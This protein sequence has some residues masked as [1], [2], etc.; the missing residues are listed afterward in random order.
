MQLVVEASKIDNIPKKRELDGPN[1]SSLEMPDGSG[2]VNNDTGTSAHT[3]EV[4]VTTNRSLERH[5][6]FVSN[7][8]TKN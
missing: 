1:K 4:E 2:V 5:Q 3:A 7:A 8:S 6:R